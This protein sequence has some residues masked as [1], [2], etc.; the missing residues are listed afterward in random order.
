MIELHSMSRAVLPSYIGRNRFHVSFKTSPDMFK[1]VT[2]TVWGG[3]LEVRTV[4]HLIN[5]NRFYVVNF[6]LDMVPS[7]A[8]V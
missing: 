7:T 2:V 4:A 5:Q 8:H 3:V 6:P 1:T